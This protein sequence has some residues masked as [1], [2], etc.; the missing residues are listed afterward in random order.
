M[1]TAPVT[2][3]ELEQAKALL[4]RE[5][6]LSEG[7]E[8]SIASGLMA[9]SQRGL[10]LDEPERAA[11]IYLGITAAEVE[12]AFAKWIRPDGFVEAVQGPMPR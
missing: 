12:A 5:I 3:A 1:Q 4:L 9:R 6:P 11:R 2:P 7:D 8:D 10:P